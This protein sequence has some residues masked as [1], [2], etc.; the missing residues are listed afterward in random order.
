MQRNGREGEA[1]AGDI[2]IRGLCEMKNKLI[3][4]A[5]FALATFVLG[6]CASAPWETGSA[7][8]GTEAEEIALQKADLARREAALAEKLSQLE[9]EKS[10]LEDAHRD[11]QSE[12]ATML[13][14]RAANS[15]S[16]TPPDPKPGECYARK[17]T[18]PQYQ[19]FQQS[20]K[21]KPAVTELIVVPA[22]YEIKEEKIEITPAITKIIEVPAVFETRQATI[23]VKDKS[24]K[25]VV[26][27]AVYETIEVSILVE[28][29][30]NALEVIDAEYE[31]VIEHVL[32][33]EAGTAWMPGK[34]IR[35]G[36]QVL[37]TRIGD[38]GELMCLVTIAAVYKDVPTQVLKKAASTLP[39]ESGQAK[40]KTV[41]KTVLKTAATTREDPIPATYRT[42]D[43]QVL[44]KKASTLKVEIAPPEYEMVTQ[45]K[46]KTE[47]TTRKNEIPAAYEIVTRNKKIRDEQSEWVPVLCQNNNT[48]PENVTALQLALKERGLYNCK[49]DGI[50]GDCTMDAVNLFAEKKQ[51]WRGEN[52]VTMKVIGELGLTF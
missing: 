25:M 35:D 15:S 6:G 46:Q 38:T 42:V 5:T 9:A 34:S 36:R 48:T 8:T 32:V 50:I 17:F 7:P 43:K 4:M 2:I 49:V 31:T 27:P 3:V 26:I 51:L 11:M 29:A 47:A 10:Q 44:V 24:T 41:K 21:I 12:S 13:A 52:F 30:P 23:L 37:K 39:D 28:E 19:A 40:Y 20:V 22:V 1:I 45:K 18:Y 16:L 14:S 33:R